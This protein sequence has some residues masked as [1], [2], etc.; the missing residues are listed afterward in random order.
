[1]GRQARQL[2]WVLPFLCFGA[3]W[4]LHEYNT[5]ASAPLSCLLQPASP[6]SILSA[7][8]ATAANRT[9]TLALLP[10]THRLDIGGGE[11]QAYRQCP[12]SFQKQE[13]FLGQ[14]FTLE[15]PWTSMRWSRRPAGISLKTS[16]VWKIFASSRC[17]S[18]GALIFS[19]IIMYCGERCFN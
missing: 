18:A 4:P 11:A 16:N 12:L 2:W 13:N 8:A 19:S 9:L 17:T 14:K 15:F 1:M 7:G 10:A 6:Q 5:A 3:H